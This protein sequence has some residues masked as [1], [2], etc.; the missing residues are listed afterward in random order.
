M[1]YNLG[2]AYVNGVF[3]SSTDYSWNIPGHKHQQLLASVD[4]MRHDEDKTAVDSHQKIIK[5]DSVRHKL[6]SGTHSQAAFLGV[7]Y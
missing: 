6:L 5:L 2:F 1:V 7:T 4:G 3:P